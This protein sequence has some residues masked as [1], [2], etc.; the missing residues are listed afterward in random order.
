MQSSQ[1]SVRQ[2][3]PLPAASTAYTSAS[4]EILLIDSEVTTAKLAPL[5]RSRYR[6]AVTTTVAAARAFL[7]RNDVDV[8]VTDIEL[9][10][11]TAMNLC[12]EAKTLP[13]P[14]VVLVTTEQ[15]HRA[16]EALDARCDGILLKPFALNLLFAR[17][18]RMLRARGRNIT[19]LNSTD[20]GTHRHWQHLRCPHCASHGVTSFEF[21]SHRRA[22]FACG[23][24][25]K[26]WLGKRQE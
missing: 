21:A 2:L 8:I 3:P 15:V 22:W 6:V 24:C 11:G 9:P 20:W 12:R 25:K 14:P 26:V 7:G 5:L 17:I 1:Q 19:T 18:G 4:P 10:D 16:P 23:Q 13:K